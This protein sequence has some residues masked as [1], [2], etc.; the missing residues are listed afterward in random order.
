MTPLHALLA[1]AEGSD[2]IR[3]CWGVV[4]CFDGPCDVIHVTQKDQDVI[5]TGVFLTNESDD[6]NDC[7]PS[8]MLVRFSGVTHWE[9]DYG[10]GK[11]NGIKQAG[12]FSSPP[13][14][15]ISVDAHTFHIVCRQVAILSCEHQPFTDLDDDN[16]A[17]S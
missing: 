4:P 9:Y 16:G 2:L 3:K 10:C 5:L 13:L 7:K 11:R 6:G 1:E 15:F 8:L 14:G 17:A 12:V